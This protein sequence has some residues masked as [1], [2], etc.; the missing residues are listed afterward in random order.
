[1]P[2][3]FIIQNDIAAVD[4]VLVNILQVQP[5]TES[6][7]ESAELLGSTVSQ[8]TTEVRSNQLPETFILIYTDFKALIAQHR[9]TDQRPVRLLN[10]GHI[11]KVGVK[12]NHLLHRSYKTT[13]SLKL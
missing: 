11:R 5:L 6:E 12:L 13:W 7:Q 10:G 2:W 4:C 8:T 1:M 3:H 9:T